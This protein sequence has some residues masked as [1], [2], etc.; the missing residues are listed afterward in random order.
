MFMV[1]HINYSFIKNISQKWRWGIVIAYTLAMYIFLPFGPQFWMYVLG[2]WG[3]SINYMGWFFVC[4]LGAYFLIHLIFQKEARE[5]AVYLAFFLISCAC[6]VILKYMC[7][8]GPERFHPLMYGILGCIVF[9]AFKNDV[10]K[11]RVYLYTTILVFFLGL[12]DESIQCILPMRVFDVK[13]ILINWLSGGMAELFIAFV[14]K[15]NIHGN[16]VN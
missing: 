5:P 15:P 12:I 16:M 7:S 13:D 11:T 6:L 3:D 2:Q 10:K 4:V 14:L 1:L 9:W 8:T